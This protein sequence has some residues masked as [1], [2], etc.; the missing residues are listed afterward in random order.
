MENALITGASAG[1]GK[2]LAYV[3]AEKGY[4]LILVA[5]RK[6]RLESIKKELEEKNNVSVEIIA[7]DLSLK[8]SAEILYQDVL[9]KNLKVDVLINNAGFGTYG[10]FIDKDINSDEGMILLNIMSLTKLTKLFG[11][12]MMNQGGGNIVNIASTASFQPVPNLA[13]YAATKAYVLNFSE[14]I[15]FELKKHKVYVTAICPGATKSEFADV[16]NMSSRPFEN[17]PSARQLAEFTYRKMIQRKVHAIHGF[18]NNMLIFS[19]RFAPRKLITLIAS[20]FM[21]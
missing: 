10:D 5:R 11:R 12:L 16:A 15:A 6:E 3:Y 9:D 1:I 2:E 19:T 7:Q 20:K 4:N 14:A 21:E 8:D 18:A 13:V 17:A